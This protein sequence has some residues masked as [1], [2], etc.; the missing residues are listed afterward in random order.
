MTTT[1]SQVPDAPADD[2]RGLARVLAAYTLSATA[3]LLFATFVGI[4]IAYKFG[5]PEF[6]SGAWLTFGRLRPIHT[7]DTFYGFASIALVGLAY[8]IAA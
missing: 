2:E 6:G 5:A 3:W 8:Y 1:R 4:L 7:N